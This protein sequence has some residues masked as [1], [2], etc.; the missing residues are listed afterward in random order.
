MVR[1]GLAI[2]SSLAVVEQPKR[3]E[4]E[5][6]N[7]IKGDTLFGEGA[8]LAAWVSLVIERSGKPDVT[9][10]DMQT[11]VAAHWSRGLDILEDHWV[12]AEGDLA[13]VHAPPDRGRRSGRRVGRRGDV[14][15][16]PR[17]YVHPAFGRRD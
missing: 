10:R 15:R 11:M 17:R 4:G 14:G 1:R 8:D 9:L 7:S 6:G 2:A 16:R 13:R 3:V 12:A 5:L